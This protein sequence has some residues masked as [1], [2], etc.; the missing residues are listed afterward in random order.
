VTE[1]RAAPVAPPSPFAWLFARPGPSGI[2]IRTT[3]TA[4]DGTFTF[5]DAPAGRY[6][7]TVRHPAMAEHDTAVFEL[8]RGRREVDVE[9]LRNARLRGRV[10]G[11]AIGRQA[12]VAVLVLGGYG[13]Q[14]TVRADAAGRYV[15]DGL[16]PGRYLV[17]AFPADASRYVD[18]LLGELF[19][20][21]AGELA[22]VDG[23]RPDVELAPGQDAVLD[24]ALDVQPTG[25]VRGTVAVNGRA[26]GSA[27]IVLRPLPGEAPGSGGLPLRAT[28]DDRG[29]FAFADVPAGSYTL[30]VYGSSRAELHREAIAVAPG[31]VTQLAIDTEAGGVQGRVVAAGGTRAEELRGS[32][33]I[34]PGA[35]E[36]PADLYAFRRDHRT[37]RLRIRDGAFADVELTPG[38]ALAVVDLPGRRRVVQSIAIPAR[39]TVAIELPAG[40]RR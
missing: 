11:A 14:R 20:E 13:T 5:A 22:R 23:P 28:C 40:E 8:T 12:G 35:T 25:G 2:A 29:V 36:E 31:G 34:L 7:L 26:A 16:Q 3:V 1:I 21:R 4:G 15:V 39:G 32:V 9:L 18:R 33:W 27:R 37:H 19:P 38:A 10:V 24:V 6:R 30:S 17:R